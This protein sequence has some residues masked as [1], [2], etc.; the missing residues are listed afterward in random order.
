MQIGTISLLLG[1][2]LMPP[3]AAF[4]S[5]M[6][7]LP[8]FI[9][10]L[11]LVPTGTALPLSGLDVAGQSTDAA[12]R[13]GAGDGAQQTFR[14]IMSI[15]GPVG[16]TLVFATLGHGVPFLIAAAIVAVAGCSPSA[17]VQQRRWWRQPPENR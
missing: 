4:L 13:A 6:R 17:S 15:V 5:P 9:V 14:G 1:L 10:F 11:I 7:A 8:L 12:T 16:A 3:A 2:A